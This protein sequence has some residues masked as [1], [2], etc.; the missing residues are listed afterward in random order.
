MWVST[1]VT[2]SNMHWWSYWCF[3]TPWNKSLGHHQLKCVSCITHYIICQSPTHPGEVFHVGE[4]KKG[5]F[6]TQNKRVILCKLLRVCPSALS[7]TVYTTHSA[8][9]KGSFIMLLIVIGQTKTLA[10]PCANWLPIIFMWFSKCYSDPYHYLIFFSHTYTGTISS[11][12][13]SGT[14]AAYA[15]VQCPMTLSIQM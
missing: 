1:E 5:N 11:L 3:A 15:L 2:C 14:Y 4:K 12:L 9:L 8:E 7:S 6:Q 10:R 13:T